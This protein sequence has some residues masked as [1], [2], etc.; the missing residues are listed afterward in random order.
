MLV[1]L[2]SRCFRNNG[3]VQV[4]QTLV[5]VNYMGQGAA[6]ELPLLDCTSTGP[7]AVRLC[8]KES[9]AKAWPLRSSPHNA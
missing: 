6:M 8:C 5:D 1:A 2:P 9:M 3:R 4:S 7:T